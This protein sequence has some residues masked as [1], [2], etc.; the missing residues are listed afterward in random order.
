MT[1]HKRRTPLAI[2][3]HHDSSVSGNAQLLNTDSSSIRP[4]EDQSNL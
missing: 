3:V 1:N 2:D 4:S